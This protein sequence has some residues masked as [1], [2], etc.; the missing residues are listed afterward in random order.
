MLTKFIYNT[1]ILGI[2]I[3]KSS[4]CN[5]VLSADLQAVLKD[6]YTALMIIVPLLVIFMSTVD[7]FR[8]V[9][10]QDEKDMTAARGRA[11]KRVIIGM[12]T[13]FV[14]IILDI[15]LE[16]AGIASGTCGIGG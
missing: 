12:A 8:A 5:D 16:L 9:V 14:P 3:N 7:I 2:I 13:F 4:A 10:A 1:N 11:I 15:V 6:V